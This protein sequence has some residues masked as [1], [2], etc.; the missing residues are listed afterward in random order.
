MK[1]LCYYSESFLYIIVQVIALVALILL[2]M[3]LELKGL[4]SSRL[5][6]ICVI[7]SLVLIFIVFTTIHQNRKYKRIK[8]KGK[9][10]AGEIIE[11]IEEY[12]KKIGFLIRSKYYVRVKYLDPNTNEVVEM[13]TP[14]LGFNPF[15]ELASNSCSVYIDEK[16]IYVSDFIYA[17]TEEE[18]IWHSDLE[19]HNREVLII[20]LVILLLILICF[21]QL[22]VK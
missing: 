10:V 9:K 14:R 13:I 20:F 17:K 18:A 11:P 15:G 2:T 6:W 22:I 8:K 21:I 7:I 19:K 12:Q 3:L 1:K 4:D 16:G 5:Y